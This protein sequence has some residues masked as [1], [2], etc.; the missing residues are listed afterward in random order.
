LA[1]F[2]Q[3]SELA[4]PVMI[5]DDGTL[6]EDGRATLQKLFPFTR[7]ITRTEADA[8]VGIRLEAFPFCADFRRAHPRALKVFDAP[9]YAASERFLFFDNELLFFNYPRE[10]VEWVA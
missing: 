3:F 9:H 1:S 8:T 6:P 7:V 2:F 10:I 4:W 5:H